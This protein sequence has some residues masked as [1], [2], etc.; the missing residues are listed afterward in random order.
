MKNYTKHCLPLIVVILFFT[1]CGKITKE[2]GKDNLTGDYN[3]KVTY[4]Y[5]YSQLNIGIE[6]TERSESCSVKFYAKAKI[7][8]LVITTYPD[9][10]DMNIDISGITLLVNGTSFNIPQQI[11]SAG[12]LVINLQG[13][14]TIE[15]T[16]GNKNDGFIDDK[17]N[18]YFS[19]E[20]VLPKNLNGIDS[21]LPFEAYYELKKVAV[22]KNN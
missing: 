5:K 11:T 7:P 12:D 19:F 20:G 18:L 21:N 9:L 15:D 10:V 6:D 8:S 22:E 1:S 3:G 14:Q 2:I 13:I 17:D 16:N 4:V